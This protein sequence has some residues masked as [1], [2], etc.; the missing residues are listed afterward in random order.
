ML[1]FLRLQFRMQKVTQ[2]QLKNFVG[3]WLTEEE[4]K[5]IVNE[6]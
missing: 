1:E 3:T 2:E 6:V 5:T 4:Y